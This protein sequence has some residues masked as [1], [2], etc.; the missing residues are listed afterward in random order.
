MCQISY[1][2]DSSIIA[3]RAS[4]YGATA[5]LELQIFATVATLGTISLTI[6]AMGEV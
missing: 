2:R 4:R 1:G 5:I 3:V 6:F